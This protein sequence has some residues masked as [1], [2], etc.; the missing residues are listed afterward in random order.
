MRVVIVGGGVAG[1]TTAHRLLEADPGLDVTVLE[2]EPAVGGRLRT[3]TVGDLRLESGPDSFVARKPWAVDLCRELGLELLEPGARDAL[4]WTERGL[5]PLPESALGVPTDLDEIVRWP[6][7]SRRGRARALTELIRKPRPPKTD[8]SIGSL[9]RR[10]M[11]DEVAERLTGPLLGGLFAGDVDRLSVDATFPELARWER[12]FGSLIRGA[13]AAVKAAT[14]AGPMFLR[15][16][17]GVGELPRALLG[18]VGPG[19]VRVG[20]PARAIERERGSFAV[21]T[22]RDS[23]SAE[24]VVLAAPAFVAAELVRGLG[25]AGAES[26]AAIAYASTGVVH[27][28]YAEGTADALPAATG[29]VVPRG[30]APMTAATFV[31]RKWPEDAFGTRAVL[32]CFVGAVGFEDVLDEPDEDIVEAVCRHL[33]AFLS[34]PERADASSVVRWP[35]SMPQYEV[36]HLQ[37][38]RAIETS[39]PPGI[40]VTGNA[41][42]GVGVADAVR[43]AGETAERV[44]AHLAGPSGLGDPN[45]NGS[46]PTRSENVG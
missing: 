37:R 16:V 6:G 4:I 10:R 11:G 23:V 22:D 33:S 28:V 24:A 38:V 14:D 30:R 41:L 39:L 26:L 18:S 13:R 27:L 1:L 45:G 5:V 34:L 12:A 20:V 25:V 2:S 42:H 3:A 32:R 44:R 40:F 8:E 46:T 19:R 31:S 15:P 9:V 7:L 29:F 17:G 35:R 36:G 21:R 43:S